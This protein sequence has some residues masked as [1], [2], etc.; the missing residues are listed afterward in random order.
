VLVTPHARNDDVVLLTT[1]EG[2]DRSNLDLLVK[3]LLERP[4]DLHERDEV[5]PLTFVGG[6]DTDL[7]GEDAGLEEAGDDLLD[8]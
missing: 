5:G 7:R 3:L 6:D 4:V 2:V 8:V 1:L